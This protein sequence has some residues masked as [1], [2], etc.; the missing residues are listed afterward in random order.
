MTGL[1]EYELRRSENIAANNILLDRLGLT[2]SSGD[3][4]AK[5]SRNKNSTNRLRVDQKPENVI[6]SGRTAIDF[7]DT[8]LIKLRRSTRRTRNLDVEYKIDSEVLFRDRVRK[9]R[10]AKGAETNQTVQLKSRSRHPMQ[11]PIPPNSIRNLNANTKLLDG[12]V[13]KF[14]PKNISGA[15]MK[16]AV[17]ETLA[18]PNRPTYNKMSG[19][20]EWRNCIFLF[21]NLDSLSYKNTF[22][23]DYERLV[24]FAQSSQT[25]SSPVICRLIRSL[26]PNGFTKDCGHDKC[27]GRLR[28]E[29]H[30]FCRPPSQPYFYLGEAIAAEFSTTDSLP[31]KFNLT[32]AN[33]TQLR[34]SE[35][36]VDRLK[37]IDDE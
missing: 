14:F 7:V 23:D 28:A 33:V 5:T 8:E 25:L 29:V 37:A 1:S 21:I 12:Y 31:I 9:T 18:A 16:R 15:A 2:S 24:W 19:I 13:G 20:Q 34:D 35:L 30:L 32:L 17:M 6:G 27:I 3:L 10:T 26:D 11:A 22:R 36:F 4:A